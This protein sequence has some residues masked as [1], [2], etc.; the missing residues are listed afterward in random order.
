MPSK[1]RQKMCGEKASL[2]GRLFAF[3]T[4]GY[5]AQRQLD[6]SNNNAC[7]ILLVFISNGCIFHLARIPNRIIG[8]VTDANA[9]ASG[10][11]AY[12]TDPRLCSDGNVS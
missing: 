4:G 6:C 3:W 8:C 10:R 11:S 1:A 5:G 9:R 7:K 2:L 12:L